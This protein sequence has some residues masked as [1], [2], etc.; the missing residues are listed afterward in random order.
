MRCLW[1]RIVLVLIFLFICFPAGTQE[2]KSETKPA[3]DHPD[4]AYVIEHDIDRWVFEN[5]GTGTREKTLQVRIQ[6]D[7]GVQEYGLLN[8]PYESAAENVEI[9]YVRVRKPD[10]TI[11]TTPPDD[12]QDLPMPVTREAPMYSD[13]R[14]KQVAV[15]G[16]NSGDVLEFQS[17]WKRSKPLVP[18]QF[19]LESGFTDNEISLDEELQVSV[20]RGRT[21]KINSPRLAP[22]V[23]EEGDR[24]IYQ[25]SR[26]N[27]ERATPTLKFDRLYWRILGRFP[28]PD[29][30]LTSFQ[31]W[32]ELGRWYDGLQRDRITPSPEIR[33]KAAELTRN[34]NDD[35]AKIHAIYRYVSS[36]FRY[37]GVDFGIGRYQPHSAAEVFSNQ[38]GDCKDKHTLMASLLNA[39]G[40]QAY[41]ALV[42]SARVVD[43]DLPS[44]SQF[45][46]V[47]TVIPRG[48]DWLWLDSTAEV[49]PMGYLS[50]QLRGKQALV[51]FP[52]KPAVF[53]M[54][55]AN[56]PFAFEWNFKID[57]KL[58]DSG[59]LAG[60]VEQSI[61]GGSEVLWR[62]SLRG[63]PRA[64]WKDFI[65]R[66]SYSLGFAGEVTDVTA[67]P[68]EVTDSPFHFTYSYKRKQYPDWENHR[69]AIPAPEILLVPP[70]ENG[71]LPQHLWLGGPGEF[72]FESRVEV[73]AGYE[74]LL[75]ARKDVQRDFAEY[76]AIYQLENNILVAHFR[77]VVKEAEVAG[78]KVKEYKQ[79]AEEVHKDRERFIPIVHAGSASG[80]ISQEASLI[81][82]SGIWALP[83]TTD[84]K[85]QMFE[86]QARKAMDD[87]SVQLA[88]EEIRR[89]VEQDPKFTRG[90]IMLGQVEMMLHQQSAGIA[91]F[92]KAVA[93]D[94]K[95]PV[96][97]KILALALRSIGL[98]RDA[99]LAWQDLAKVDPEDNDIP[100]NLSTLLF[101][102]KRFEEAVPYLE[103]AV[104]LQP[105]RAV[106]LIQLG[107]A[108][109]HS[110]QDEKAIGVFDKAMQLDPGAGT[111]N[112][113]SYAM[114]VANK[115]LDD[116]LH[117]GEEAVRDEE[118]A[119]Q[120]V[121][122][123][124]LTVQDLQHT[125]NLGF[126]WDTLGW[127]QFRRSDL[128]KAEDYLYA[129][130]MLRQDPVTGYHLAQVYEKMARNDEAVHL[131]RLIANLR[132][133]SPEA[134]EAI[135][136]SKRKTAGT[137]SRAA[138]ARPPLASVS[139]FNGELSRER[140]A[141]LPKL[142]GSQEAIA[143][144]F[145][146]FVPS[147]EPGPVAAAHPNH[148]WTVA[149]TRF[150]KGSD[151]LRSAGDALRK[152][153]FKVAFPENSQAKLIR[154]G[155]L[156]CYPLTGCSFVLI[157]TDS[158][159]SVD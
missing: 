27:L 17:R 108:Y 61:R 104:A 78:D 45:D 33:A 107:T 10:S 159:T 63:L 95:Q 35:F 8:F 1:W 48:K 74:P 140:T 30:R 139:D 137:A 118:A 128:K 47:I 81:L 6:S 148:G 21:V 53:Q 144:F 151:L 80:P 97:Y 39:A 73:P 41:P 93:S 18:G 121:Q 138:P 154:R 26:S 51:I 115:R 62:S 59:T 44:P 2:K 112:E 77:T 136:E 110:N 70:E 4:E 130:W 76:H 134:W 49:A 101:A 147:T 38:Y 92:R 153:H 15:K 69:I 16:L 127:V 98:R 32:E 36:E 133:S 14:E 94:P 43:P 40:I 67:S 100:T 91:A 116:A 90:W 57:A 42:N 52:D 155:F 50:S 129:A 19:W 102:E 5:D 37:I 85:A 111:R 120:K 131:Y 20:P 12:V 72:H 66:I 82:Q 79:F 142:V 71:K 29:V 152:A 7:A 123:G 11:V 103:K 54:V 55:P 156:S 46:H 132:S 109:L 56:L 105:K 157:P 86:E 65:Q 89:A 68:P 119:S 23:K 13:L 58:D 84:A 150:I 149:D 143:E 25:W 96:A 114:A 34:L 75:P 83:D 141:A 64:E 28:V 113:I 122:L 87:N 24:R 60:K 88:A 125:R 22:A 124:T 126:Y 9:I 135:A 158:V 106:L 99:I 145:L 146:A 31:S 117:Y 3:Q